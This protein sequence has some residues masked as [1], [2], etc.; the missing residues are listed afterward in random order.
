MSHLHLPDGLLPIWII[1]AGFAA[2]GILLALCLRKLRGDEDFVRKVSLLAILSALML[3]AMSVP[4]GFIHYHVNLTVLVSLLVGPWLAFI[5]VFVVNFFL[6][7]IGH[8]G[9]SVMGL[10]TL[11]VGSEVFFAYYIFF[12]LRR[13]LKTIP[14]VV[15]TTVLTL[16]LSS[17]LMVSVV[18]TAGLSPALL[19]DDHDHH[20]CSHDHG[21]EEDDHDHVHAQPH[22]NGGGFYAYLEPFFKFI[23]PLL[24][25]GALIEAAV[26]AGIVG[27]LQKVK[28]LLVSP[29]YKE[30]KGIKSEG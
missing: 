2:T 11:V 23:L 18:A 10:N 7:F 13:F 20:E 21:H 30:N 16:V 25:V 5:G 17:F 8:G 3:V 27:Y 15:G 1:A 22:D 28:P 24:V 4:L 6:S 12:G 14:A 9:I 29:L 19:G 26:T